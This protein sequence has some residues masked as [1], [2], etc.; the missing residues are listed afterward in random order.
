LRKEFDDALKLAVQE[1]WVDYRM[2]FADD[3][4]RE[5]VFPDEKFEAP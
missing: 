2:F 4:S 3:D 1:G 5:M